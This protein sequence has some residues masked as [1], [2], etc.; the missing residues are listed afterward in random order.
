MFDE[1]VICTCTGVT[2]KA[3]KEAFENGAHTVTDIQAETGAGTICGACL[4]K[5]EVL[6]NEL[7][8]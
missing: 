3:I 8:R 6:L 4:D 5:I 1:E 7:K 2:V